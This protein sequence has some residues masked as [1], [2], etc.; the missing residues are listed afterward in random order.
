MSSAIP[1]DVRALLKVTGVSKPRLIAIMVAMA[2]L[3]AVL[4]TSPPTMNNA[5]TDVLYA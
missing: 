2:F 3:S 4:I 5:R 1:A